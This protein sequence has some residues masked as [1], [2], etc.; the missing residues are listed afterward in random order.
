MIRSNFVMFL[1]MFFFFWVLG[2]VS[3]AYLNYN[4]NA[5]KCEEISKFMEA[6]NHKFVSEECFL[7][8]H[9]RP[10]VPYSKIVVSR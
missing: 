4:F 10:F 6:E 2:L 3:W 1:L 7:K 5:S 8:F 9:G